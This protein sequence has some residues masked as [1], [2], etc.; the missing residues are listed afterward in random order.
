MSGLLLWDN[1]LAKGNGIAYGGVPSGWST[2][3]NIDGFELERCIDGRLD[4]SAKITLAINFDLQQKYTGT[5]SFSGSTAIRTRVVLAPIHRKPKGFWDGWTLTITS[6]PSA[7][8]TATVVPNTLEQLNY[9]D[10]DSITVQQGTWD[11]ELTFVPE[12]DTVAFSGHNFYLSDYFTPVF[13]YASDSTSNLNE[14]LVDI[15]TEG[16]VYIHKTSQT[17]SKRYVTLYFP[18]FNSG[19]NTEIPQVSNFYVGKSLKIENVVDKFS[20][21]A[22][23]TPAGIYQTLERTG[24]RNNNNN[25]LPAS[26][27]DAPFDVKLDFKLLDEEVLRTELKKGLYES[28]QTKPF[29]LAWDVEDRLDNG[30]G[31]DTAFCW[32]E[33]TIKPPRVKDYTGRVEW[34]IDAKGLKR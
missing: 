4:T 10:V 9:I 25:P 23:F 26:Y 22:P 2:S 6:G 19:S 12:W 33:K 5:T 18:S 8:A 31:A 17:Y 16:N 24:K 15:N 11:Y 20:L 30:A 3:D 1:L 28:L 34:T 21:R 7:G 13:L 29:Y 27:R 14:A 32:V